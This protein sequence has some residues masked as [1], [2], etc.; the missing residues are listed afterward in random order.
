MS[1]ITRELDKLNRAL[2]EGA[3]N[4]RYP[5][6]Y[7][8][9]QALRWALDPKAYRAPYSYVMDIQEGSGDYPEY[10]DQPQSSGISCQVAQQ[11]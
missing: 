8:A 3:D 11:Q 5:E 2:C 1:F 7:A 4:P 9:Q 6:I 10:L